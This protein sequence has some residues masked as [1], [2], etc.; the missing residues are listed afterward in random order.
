[1]K[2]NYTDTIL[3]KFDRLTRMLSSQNN[4]ERIEA[5][6]EVHKFVKEHGKEVCDEM[7]AVLKR[8]DEKRGGL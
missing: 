8:R 2:K 7:F 6:I 1:V 3:R 4:L 5:R